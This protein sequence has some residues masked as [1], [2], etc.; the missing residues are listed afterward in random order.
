MLITDFDCVSLFFFWI[1][2]PYCGHALV[3]GKMKLSRG[4]CSHLNIL[5]F[6]PDFD[7]LDPRL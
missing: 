2:H 3:I 1:P 5:L 6:D 4:V 7:F